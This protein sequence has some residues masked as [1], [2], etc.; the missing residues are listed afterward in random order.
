MI[1]IS[2]IGF[3]EYKIVRP[4]EIKESYTNFAVVG[5]SDVIVLH[6]WEELRGRRCCLRERKRFRRRMTRKRM[7]RM[8]RIDPYKRNVKVCLFG[9]ETK[10]C[11]TTQTAL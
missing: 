11:N 3:G 5:R 6:R 7:T 9:A 1:G 10:C 4:F 8:T 2:Y